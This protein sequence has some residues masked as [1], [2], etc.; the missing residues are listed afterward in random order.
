M[1]S[2]R[3]HEDFTPDLAR[4]AGGPETTVLR[5]QPLSTGAT[6]TLCRQTLGA[7]V[8]PEFATACREATGGNPFFLGELLREVS[9]RKLS[10]DAREA[11]RIRSIGPAAVA[12]AV[13]LRLSERPAAA[14][15]LVRAMAVL[16]DG[17]GLEE[18]ARLA[19]LGDEEAARA[20]DLLAA[21]GIRRG[22][23]LEF[24]HPIVREAVYADIGSH[25][26]AEAHA[27]AARILAASGAP[28]E[29]IAAQ[30][31]AA[32]PAG[33]PERVE[34]LRRVAAD[35]V[36]RG[37][38]AAAVALL[39]RALREPPRAESR[40]EVL[41]DLSSA[42]LRL[43]TPEAAIEQLVE[44]AEL[45]QGAGPLTTATRLLGSAL[46]WSGNADRA[47]TVIGSA[48]ETVES[49]DRELA[50]LLE[51]DRAAYAH[52]A[53]LDTRRAVAAQLR[54]RG[55]LQG[56]TPGERLVL[57]SLAYERARASKSESETVAFIER[58]L[59]DGRLVGEQEVDVAGTLYLLVV[60]LLATDALDVAEATLERM[61]E[62]ARARASIPA[63]AFVMVHR[64]WV[65]FRQGAVARAEA[66][67]R[68]TLELLTTYD[69]RLGTRFA[70]ALLVQVLMEGGEHEAA[71][72]AL[73]DSV[74]GDEIPP[75]LANND[76]LE[77]RAMLQIAQGRTREGLDDLLEFGRRDALW[78]SVSPLASRWASRAAL[79]LA[80][81]GDDEGA[82]RMAADDLERA[83][84]WGAAGGIGIALR[85]TALIE[86]GADGVDR[87]RRRPRCSGD[88]PCDSNTLVRS[89]TW[90]PPSAVPTAAPRPV[91][92][93][94]K[95][96]NSP[97]G[98][99]Q[100][101][102]SHVP[103]RS[104]ARPGAAQ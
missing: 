79:A 5:P 89:S 91:A 67:A 75:G 85:A 29:R 94:R 73:R 9:E 12:E 16:G 26:R 13:L 84:R 66:D 36:V 23:G 64:G 27:R 25:E 76:L 93:S 53:S 19:G 88:R 42:E 54:G 72:R 62:D 96:W 82:R 77:A 102:S 100:P 61:L 43:G 11:T 28:G 97:S 99:G 95:G 6:A 41:L 24:S 63:Q 30:I 47:V 20:A 14:T 8:A 33:D 18:A 32:E 15:G 55:D 87:L 58:A 22:E 39:G 52:Q 59:A 65:S 17:A 51:A 56:A 46:T 92:R 45:A 48:I 21:V 78:G 71:A 35:A 2:A 10:P 81:T 57:A 1:R 103:V 101:R 80:A 86:G 34:L 38:P 7:D 31:V 83:R 90:A 4:I 69:I 104:W 70:L 37:A 3:S 98:A 50:L 49:E 60:G 44:A 74:L 40:W 68:T